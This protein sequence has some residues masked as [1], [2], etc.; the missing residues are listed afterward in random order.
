MQE[1]KLRQPNHGSLF[2]YARM[3]RY[4]LRN[5]LICRLRDDTAGSQSIANS[6]HGVDH[7]IPSLFALG[8]API[9]GVSCR[10][11]I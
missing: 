9:N 8:G 10:R 3:H 6:S 5:I 2:S 7:L 1:T 4:F 11:E